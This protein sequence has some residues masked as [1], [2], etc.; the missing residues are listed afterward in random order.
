[1]G[2]KLN[3]GRQKVFTKKN[4]ALH[5]VLT[6]LACVAV[7]ALG[8]FGAQL[9]DK[10]P[11]ADK[12]DSSASDTPDTTTTTTTSPSRPTEPDKPAGT[13]PSTLSDVR[14]FYLPISALRDAANLP[15]TLKQ[16]A[17]AGFNSVVFDLKDSTGQ[18]NYRFACQPAQQVN[19]YTAE[20]FTAE[21][22]TQLF[23][24]LRE[25][26]LEPLPRLYAFQDHLGAKALAAARITPVGNSGWVWYDNDPKTTGRAW[27]NPYADEAHSYIIQLAQE[28][29]AAGVTGILLDGV[30]FP[31]QT[32]SASYGQST[33]TNLTHGEVLTLFV[34]KAKK[35]LD[36]CAV[37]LSCTAQGALGTDTAVYGDNPLTFAPTMASPA[38]LPGSL[39]ATIRIGDTVVKNTPDALQQTVQALVGQMV[40]RTKVMEEGKQ[41]VLL[42]W[43]QAEGYSAAQIGQE[44]AGCVAGGAKQYILYHPAGVYDFAALAG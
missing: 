40:L 21:E 38:I 18:L 13:Q 24:T 9:L 39:P 22:L 5:T 19:S 25:A 33:N 14:A 41:P 34:D 32:S 26:G 44:I 16:A 10:L 27:L 29:K 8:F 11:A 23:A 43:L 12:P 28:L 31:K 1:M 20:A 4:T 37:I 2:M 15:S 42:P 7:V 35:A 3:R 6:V 17:D 36:G 30:Q